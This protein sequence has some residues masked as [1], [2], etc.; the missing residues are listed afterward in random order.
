MKRSA[1]AVFL[2]AIFV[3]PAPD[4][5]AAQG[6]D[7]PLFSQPLHLLR[8]VD[9][10]ISASSVIIDEYCAG[11]VVVSVRGALVVITDYG[12][13]QITEIDRNAGTYSISSFDEIARALP[14]P[15]EKSR[16][17]A[18]PKASLPQRRAGVSGRTLDVVEVTVDD[19]SLTIGVDPQVRISRAAVEAL[20]GA[21]YPN[22]R[23]A[24]HDVIIDAARGGRTRIQAT[25][26]SSADYSLPAE[27]TTTYKLD[28]DEVVVRSII[29][30]V[31]SELPPP[32]LLTIDPRWTRVESRRIRTKR[33]LEELDRLP[34]TGKRQ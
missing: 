1:V 24:E 18:A 30:R 11:N 28:G 23:A 20:I 9:D 21:A 3:A 13:Q 32:E 12:K 6:D 2:A 4:L 34:V 7:P 22:R 29:L 27:Q 5:Y 14:R 33:E 16:T 8:R 17:A 19:A 15:P 25:S 10:P 31:T 26:D